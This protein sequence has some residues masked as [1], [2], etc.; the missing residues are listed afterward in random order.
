MA[1]VYTNFLFFLQK[2][3]GSLIVENPLFTG[4]SALI[5]ESGIGRA[6]AE[7]FRKQLKK[8]GGTVTQELKKN[9]CSHIVV[10]ENME[11]GRLCRILKV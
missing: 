1:P 6:R 2:I 9:E 8:Y 3:E 11:S 7:V 5:V 10:D 4:V